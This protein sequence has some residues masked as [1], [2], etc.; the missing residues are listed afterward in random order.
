MCVCV[1][2]YL[3]LAKGKKGNKHCCMENVDCLQHSLKLYG[4]LQNMLCR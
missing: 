4:K 3:W 1:C 2:V